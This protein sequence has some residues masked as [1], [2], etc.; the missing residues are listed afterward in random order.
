MHPVKFHLINKLTW[1]SR[2]L[3]SMNKAADV[4]DWVSATDSVY[5]LLVDV[6]GKA[7]LLQDCSPARNQITKSPCFEK[8]DHIM[9]NSC[10][11]PIKKGLAPE[12]NIAPWT[13]KKRKRSLPG[14]VKGSSLSIETLRKVTSSKERGRGHYSSTRDMISM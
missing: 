12:T 4:M 10:V 3:R 2:Q 9:T 6:S 1:M 7:E 11:L 14:Q 8:R 5:N 13:P